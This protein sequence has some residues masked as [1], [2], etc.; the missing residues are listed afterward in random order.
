MHA[1]EMS[2]R[3]SKTTFPYKFPDKG[4]NLFR[5]NLIFANETIR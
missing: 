2:A 5:K 1:D 3:N 4:I